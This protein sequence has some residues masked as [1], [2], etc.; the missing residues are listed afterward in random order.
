MDQRRFRIASYNVRKAR[1]LDQRRK[2]ERVL[3]IVNN[4]NADIVVL[5]EADWRLGAR[6][7]AIPRA[8]IEKET[9]FEIVEFVG[10]GDSIGWHGNAVLIRKPMTVR[11]VKLIDLPGFEPRGAFLVDLGPLSVVA[12]HLGLLRRSRQLQLTTLNELTRSRSQTVI[13]GDFNE[14]SPNKGLEP[15]SDRFVIHSPGRSFHAR[16]PLAGLDR[17]ALSHDLE[18]TDAGVEEGP[19][20]RVASDHLPIWSDVA[21]PSAIC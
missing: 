5:Q 15:L 2:P 11:D 16:R 10:M 3:Q 12:T 19:L 7:T 6:P 21:L 1:G 14:W 18:L 9:D 13:A 20:A 17:F 8:M 4:L